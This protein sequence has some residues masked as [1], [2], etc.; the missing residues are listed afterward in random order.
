MI[1]RTLQPRRSRTKMS[2]ERRSHRFMQGAF[3]RFHFYKTVIKYGRRK[4]RT[5]WWRKT[6]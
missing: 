6:K 2:A 3:N 4:I 5:R 1:F